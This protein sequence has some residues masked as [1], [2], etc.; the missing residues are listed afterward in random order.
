M[1][2]GMSTIS[3]DERRRLCD[4]FGLDAAHLYQL[5]TGRREMEPMKAVELEVRTGGRLRRWHLRARTWHLV[6]PEL[7]GTEGAPALPAAEGESGGAHGATV[8]RCAA[9]A[10]CSQTELE[11]V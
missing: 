9:E 4:E 6:W 3:I 11:K 5:L 1:L 2:H 7:V 8:A 10:A